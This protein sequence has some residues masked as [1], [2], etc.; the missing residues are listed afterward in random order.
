MRWWLWDPTGFTGGLHH[1]AEGAIISGRWL[2]CCRCW[3]KLKVKPQRVHVRTSARAY[4]HV[5]TKSD[6]CKRERRE[7][8]D[9]ALWEWAIVSLWL[10]LP[11]LS[12]FFL[13]YARCVSL[14]NKYYFDC[15]RVFYFSRTCRNQGDLQQG[16]QNDDNVLKVNSLVFGQS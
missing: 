16:L 6:F 9:M 3:K 13:N 14:L 1:Y 10:Y 15:C 7:P 8:S 11:Y 2:K 5:F 12:N 4:T